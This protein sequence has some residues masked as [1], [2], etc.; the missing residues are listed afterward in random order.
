MK[1]TVITDGTE[2]GTKVC[3]ARTGEALEGVREFR[4]E[5]E[6]FDSVLHL[7]ILSPLVSRH[8]PPPAHALQSDPEPGR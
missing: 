1:L 3:D 8:D 4:L 6:P 5:V 7:T 2:K